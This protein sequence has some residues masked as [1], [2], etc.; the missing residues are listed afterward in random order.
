M[1]AVAPGEGIGLRP[2]ATLTSGSIGERQRGHHL[3]RPARCGCHPRRV[4][5]HHAARLCRD[6]HGIG[7]RARRVDDALGS[8]TITFNDNGTTLPGCANLSPVSGAATCSVTYG[9]TDGGGH[10]ITATSTGDNVNYAGNSASQTVQVTIPSSPNPTTT[11]LSASQS[12]WPS[13]PPSC[14]PPPSRW[15]RAPS[16]SPSRPGPWRSPTAERPSP[17][18][19]RRRSTRRTSHLFDKLYR[20]RQSP[21]HRPVQR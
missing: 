13:T 14:S 18:A 7:R 12:T 2:T 20:D 9:L 21:D 16:R 11:T 6:V 19:V 1:W 15:P 17:G 3:Q 5:G 10:T 8:G 4:L